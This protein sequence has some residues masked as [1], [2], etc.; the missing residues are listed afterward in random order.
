LF[1]LHELAEQHLIRPID[2]CSSHRGAKP[3]VSLIPTIVV[4][5]LAANLAA[6]SRRVTNIG[7]AC[8]DED[9]QQLFALEV[10]TRDHGR[11]RA[12][13]ARTLPEAAHLVSKALPYEVSVYFRLSAT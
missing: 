6:I 2:P 9:Q 10:K 11:C 1:T 13:L 8:Q 4:E 5:L 12:L 7:K 3:Q